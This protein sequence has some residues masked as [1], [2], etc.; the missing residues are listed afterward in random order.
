M[1]F[2]FLKNYFLHQYIK[3][4]QKPKIKKSKFIKTLFIGKDKSAFP[5]MCMAAPLGC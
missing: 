2:L 4:N 5:S 1:Y 3:T